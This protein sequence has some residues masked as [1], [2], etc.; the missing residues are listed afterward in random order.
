MWAGRAFTSAHLQEHEVTWVFLPL[1][2]MGQENLDW[3]AAQEPYVLYEYVDQALPRTVNGLPQF[4][5]F[6][7]LKRD[8][9]NIVLGYIKVLEAAL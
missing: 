4:I 8:E 5:S 6:R 7:W 1:M 9:W 2:L 3:L